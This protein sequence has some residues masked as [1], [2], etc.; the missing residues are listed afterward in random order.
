MS[1]LF[2]MCKQ[3]AEHLPKV[4]LA[5]HVV[6]TVDERHATL[7]H[8]IKRIATSFRGILLRWK[9]RNTTSLAA[10]YNFTLVCE[11][12]HT[13]LNYWML[14]YVCCGWRGGMFKY[15]PRALIK[16]NRKFSKLGETTDSLDF[17]FW[18]YLDSSLTS[19][20]NMTFHFQP[21]TKQKSNRFE[22]F[23]PFFFVKQL[24]SCP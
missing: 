21:V 12:G 11:S 22:C 15:T 8:S 3:H 7:G 17:V 4:R 9:P 1:G 6:D 13:R 24:S 20:K 5:K 18:A 16:T 2:R 19:W 14:L 10:L 23:V